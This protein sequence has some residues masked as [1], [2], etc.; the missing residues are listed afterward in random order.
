MKQDD[1]LEKLKKYIDCNYENQSS[2]AESMGLSRSYISMVLNGEREPTN[3]ILHGIGIVK[4]KVAVY[5][6]IEKD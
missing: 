1:V 2:Y 6:I 4:T 5:S 3:Y